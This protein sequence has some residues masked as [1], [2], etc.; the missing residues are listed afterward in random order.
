MIPSDIENL[1][2]RTFPAIRDLPMALRQSVAKCARHLSVPAGTGLFEEGAPCRAFPLVLTGGVR[3]IKTTEEGRQ[4]LLYRI[5]PGQFCLMSSSCL[6]GQ[7]SYKA[8][9]IVSTKTELVL[10]PPE[11]F[12]ELVNQDA[13]FRTMVFRLFSGR[14]IELMQ[15]IEEVAFRRLDQRLA[16]LL[17]DRENPIY[18]SHQSLADELGSVRVIVSRLLRNFEEEGWLSL[19]RERIRLVNRDALKRVAAG[20]L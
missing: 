13:H 1:L 10:L 5:D 8:S 19:G 16:G 6:L 20:T 14:M 2:S 7:T 11:C 15:L 17:L 9:G 4:L 3:V 12:D 18:A